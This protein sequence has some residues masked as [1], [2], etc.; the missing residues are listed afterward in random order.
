MRSLGV[1]RGLALRKSLLL[2][3]FASAL[4]LLV[5]LY[6]PWETEAPAGV[7]FPGSGGTGVLGL[8]HLFSGGGVTFY[9]WSVS[10]GEAAA[11]LALLLAAACV[12]ALLR[13]GL[14]DRLPLAR[15]A[16]VLGYL[17]IGAWVA[18][19]ALAT[20]EEVQLKQL[21]HQALNLHHAY[22]A[23]IALAAGVVLVIAAPIL[24]WPELGDSASPSAWAAR[25]FAAGLLVVLLLPWHHF[26][27]R[28]ANF[29][30]LGIESFAGVFA[31]VAG[32]LA[33]TSWQAATALERVVLSG[34]AA[35]FSLAAVIGVPPAPGSLP[36]QYGAGL[37]LGLSLALTGVALRGAV[38]APPVWAV[39]REAV[40]ALVAAMC[41]VVALFL[42]WQQYCEPASPHWAYSGACFA[43]NGWGFPSGSAIGLL[44]VFFVAF[45]VLLRASRLGAVVVMIAILVGSLG[46]QLTTDLPGLAVHLGYGAYVGFAG[47]AL[48]L[49]LT[50]SSLRK[51][52]VS[53]RR[54]LVRLLPI[55][56]SLACAAIVVVPWWQVLPDQLEQQFLEFG[57][58]T[59]L[60]IPVPALAL[61]LSATWL[62]RAQSETTET[63]SL[64]LLPLAMLAVT[65][66]VLIN[67]RDAGVR[68]GGWT[69]I[70]LS[71]FLLALGWVEDR[72][73][74]EQSGLAEIFRVDRIANA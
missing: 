58:I 62:S 12:A 2:L 27:F 55:L 73:G 67:Y 33:L 51:T 7:S 18:I 42:P 46:R 44:A 6:L 68:W 54:L 25:V 20:L 64:V 38:A 45:L 41:V 8:L 11:P 14:V 32:L 57:P 56:G 16:F 71:L 19:G 61:W 70:G 15:V 47:A 1:V 29:S 30:T 48:L 69:L 31:A 3:L 13:E 10:A 72:E 9:G 63:R 35:V 65:T 52:H 4:A 59:W 74:L 53:T 23:Y 43:P 5:S 21:G 22:G 37:G 66:L 36:H 40:I 24:R 60:T 17:A 34:A 28:G 39:E 49:L 26:A 50:G